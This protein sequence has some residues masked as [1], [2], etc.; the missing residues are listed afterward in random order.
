METRERGEI[1]RSKR[2]PRLRTSTAERFSPTPFMLL[3]LR[4]RSS[5]DFGL[6]NPFTRWLI[7]GFGGYNLAFAATRF[8]AST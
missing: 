1:R 2:K 4:E 6:E 5:G 8:A 7:R 3:Q